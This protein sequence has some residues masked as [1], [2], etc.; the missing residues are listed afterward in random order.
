MK[1][2]FLIVALAATTS[3]HAQ[4]LEKFGS[5]TEKSLGP[6]KIRVPYTSVVSYL[7]Y[8]AP[9]SEDEIKD[10]KKYSY[11]YCFIPLAAP[12]LGVRMLSPVGSIAPEKASKSV[13]YDENKASTE[14]FDTYITLE[15]CF[16][17]A[18][19]KDVTEENVK[20]G[21]WTTLE[22]NDDSSEMPKNCNGSSYNSLLRFVS[23][24]SDPKGAL[25]VGLYRIGFTTYKTGEVNGTFL[26]QVASPIDL[27]GVV[28]GRLDQVMAALK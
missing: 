20:N 10:G 2:L 25:T 18:L 11:I 22:S 24:T 26:A 8:A 6:K 19:A 15:R 3:V 9:N 17:I 14:C 23:K 5:S 12:E 27:P 4:K 16:N 28:I 21:E 1:T 13:N 7:G